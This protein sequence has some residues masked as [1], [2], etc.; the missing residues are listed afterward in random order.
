MSISKENLQKQIEEMKIKLADMEAELNKPEGG[1]YYWHP[2]KDGEAY[3][4]VTEK[5]SVN[6]YRYGADVYPDRYRVFKTK[7]E[8]QKYAEYVKAEETLRRVI[9][10]SNEGWVPDWNNGRTPNYVVVL[11]DMKLVVFNYNSTKYLPN[12]M[13]IKSAELAEKLKKEYEKEFIAYLS[14]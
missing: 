11:N 10:I 14:Y 12:F 2:K 3:Y 13:Y 9:A 6:H 8:A 4:Y 7:V 1:A 5:G